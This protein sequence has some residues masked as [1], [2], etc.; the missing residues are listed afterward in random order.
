MQGFSYDANGNT[1][2]TPELDPSGSKCS[3][4]C[5]HARYYMDDEFLGGTLEDKQRG[6]LK[7]KQYF[8]LPQIEEW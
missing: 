3:P 4:H 7:Y 2:L 1:E 8:T 6:I 5:Q